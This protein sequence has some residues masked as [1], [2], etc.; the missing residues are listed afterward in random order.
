[1][2]I[3][4]PLSC[5]VLLLLFWTPFEVQ[6]IG[7]RDARETHKIEAL[8]QKIEALQDAKFVRNGSDY[9]SKT[10]AKFLRGKLKSHDKEIKTANDFIEKAASVSSTS[11]KPYVIRFKDGRKLNCGDYLK[12]EL[13][14]LEKKFDG[15]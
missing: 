15:R 5:A 1:M 7:D 8:I 6:G 13:K 4:G 14:N 10:A 11:G 3:N 12:T 9:D 2:K